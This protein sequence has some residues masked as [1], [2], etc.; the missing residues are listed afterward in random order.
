M[1]TTIFGWP[2]YRRAG[3]RGKSCHVVFD[4]RR[5]SYP[6]ESLELLLWPHPIIEFRILNK[7]ES[8]L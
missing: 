8:L 7:E 4:L 2:K 1:R 6:L 5:H 3:Q